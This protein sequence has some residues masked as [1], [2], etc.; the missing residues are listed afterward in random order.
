MSKTFIRHLYVMLAHFG[1]FGLLGLGIA[2]SS[3]L[4]VPLGNDLL[5]IAMTARNN[6]LMIYYAVMATVGSVIGCLLVDLASRRGG[7]KGL[8]KIISARQLDFIKKRITKSAGW[9]LAFACLMP[10]P[11]P[12]TA[13]VAAA[14]AFQYPRKR[15]LAVIAATRLTRFLIEGSI[16]ILI[17]RRLIRLAQ[18]PAV[19]YAVVTLIIIS[20]AGSA[21]SVRN[22]FKRSE[23]PA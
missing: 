12:F 23:A 16:A 22:W 18:T 8:E 4:F 21:F 11:F 14:A 20:I 1:G 7:E 15:L 6:H 2:D 9:A 5:F 13:F 19:E 10:P 17:G 3:F